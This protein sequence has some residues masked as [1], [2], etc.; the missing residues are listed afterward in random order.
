M[1]LPEETGRLVQAALGGDGKLRP[2]HDPPLGGRSEVVRAGK[3]KGLK[4][5]SHL[6]L[7]WYRRVLVKVKG[8]AGLTAPSGG[9]L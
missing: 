1:E 6:R 7:C 3:S 8:S 5:D 9:R 2:T 4:Q